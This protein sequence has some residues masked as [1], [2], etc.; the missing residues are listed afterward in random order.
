MCLLY[1]LPSHI[2][3]YSYNSSQIPSV[4]NL[5]Y[6]VRI[7]FPSNDVE[8]TFS[9]EC[10]ADVVLAIDRSGSMSGEYSTVLNFV[11]TIVSGFE[12]SNNQTR[13]GIIVFN[14]DASV[15]VSEVQR[16]YAMIMII[17]I[18]PVTKYR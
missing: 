1:Q 16:N 17:R 18:L 6:N 7:V 11:K 8:V 2:I 10:L 12:L 14:D 4:D 3:L 13:V 15:E 9:A 5:L